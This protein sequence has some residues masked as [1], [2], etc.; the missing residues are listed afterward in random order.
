MTCDKF[1]SRKSH[2]Q[3]N[4]IFRKCIKLSS[5]LPYVHTCFCIST[6]IGVRKSSHLRTIRKSAKSATLRA[7][8]TK[9][10]LKFNSYRTPLYTLCIRALVRTSVVFSAIFCHSAIT[11]CYL[12]RNQDL[13]LWQ[14][15]LFCCHNVAMLLPYPCNQDSVSHPSTLLRNPSY[16]EDNWH[17]NC[18]R[19]AI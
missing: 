15:K 4:F 10:M 9:H 1:F 3:R 16:E 2:S 7:A 14:Q 8:K 17:L 11:S 18:L 5:Y 13:A 6:I 12:T 19:F